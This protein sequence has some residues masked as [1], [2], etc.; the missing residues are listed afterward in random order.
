MKTKKTLSKKEIK[1]AIKLAQSEI[2]EWALF[3]KRM[4]RLLE[5]K[6]IK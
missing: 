6:I 5:D 3:I 1:E 4:E 2:R